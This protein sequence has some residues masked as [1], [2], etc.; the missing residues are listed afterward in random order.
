MKPSKLVVLIAV[1]IV[2]SI[3]LWGQVDPNVE[4][5][6]KPYGSFEGSDID[7]VSLTNG[8]LTIHQPLWSAPQRGN[9]GLTIDLIYNNKSFTAAR[10]PTPCGGTFGPCMTNVF[11]NGSGVTLLQSEG[12]SASCHMIPSSQVDQFGSPVN[13]NSCTALTADGSQ[14][15]LADTGNGYSQAIDGTGF[16]YYPATPMS[17]DAAGNANVSPALT[18]ANGNKISAAV[19]N[20]SSGGVDTLGRSNPQSITA[21]DI[22]LCPNLGYSFQSVNTAS[23]W[24]FAGPNGTTTLLMCFANVKV[25]SNF[26][27]IAGNHNFFDAVATTSMLQ[28][29]NLPD[30]TYYAFEYDAA[31]PNNSA[32]IAYGD[33]LKMTLPTGGSISYTWDTTIPCT[34]SPSFIPS[35]VVTSRKVDFND[36]NGAQ[37]WSYS[38]QGAGSVVVTDPLGK[39]TVHVITGLGGTCSLYE[40]ETDFYDGS[41]TGGTLLKTVKTDYSFTGNPYDMSAAPN[42]VAGVV[43]IHVTTI[44]PNGQQSRV[45][46]DYDS[47]FV[48]RDPLYGNPNVFPPQTHTYTVTYGRPVAKREYDWGQGAPGALLRQTL[49]TYQWQQGTN[50]YDTNNFR[51]LPYSVKILDGANHLCEETD[52]TY[53]EGTPATSNV[54]TGHGLAPGG[55]I[56]GNLTTVKRKLSTTPCAANATWSDVTSL[57]TWFDTGELKSSTDPGGHTTNHAYDPAYQGA[58]STQTCSPT[59][60]PGSIPHCVTGTYDFNTGLL[61]SFS[62]ENATQPATGNTQGDTNHT[63]TFA[64]DNMLRMTHAVSPVDPDPT[65]NNAKQDVAFGYQSAPVVFPETVTVQKL[66]TPALTDNSTAL[67][68]GLGRVFESD[69]SVQGG[70][71]TIVTKFDALSQVLS[72]TNPYFATA[73]PT[74]GITQWEYDA[75]GRVKTTIPQ[76]GTSASNNIRTDYSNFPTVTVTDQVGNPRSS[77]TDALGRLVE[78]DEPG[79]GANGPS[80]AGAGSIGISGTLHS[81]P[82]P[83]VKATGYVDISGTEVSGTFFVCFPDGSSVRQHVDDSGSVSIIVNGTTTSVG[84]GLGS[85]SST[86]ATALAGALNGGS[87]VQA[88]ASGSR[89]NFTAQTAGPNYSLSSTSASTAPT[90]SPLNSFS[91]APS[92]AAM[93]GGVAPSTTYDSGTLTVTVNGFQGSAAYN[94]N[95]NNTSTTLA[96]ALASALNVTGSPVNASAPGAS[97]TLT[98]KTTGLATN[99]SVTGSSTTSF[100]ASSTTLAGGSNAGGLFAPLVTYYSYDTLGNL[101]R[102]EQ[103]GG[104][105]DSTQWR[106]RTFTYD[107]LGRLLTAQNPESGTIRYSYDLDGNLLQKTSPLANQTG[108]ATQIVS[109]CY[110]ELHRVTDKSYT[111]QPPVIGQPCT[112]TGVVVHEAYDSGANAK[113]KL[114]SLADQAGTASYSYDVLGRLTGETRVI[115]G[116][117]K[118]LSYG[119]NVDGSIKTMTYP[120]G[121]TVTYTPDSASRSVSAIDSAHS[122]NYATGATYNAPGSMVYLINGSTGTFAGMTNTYSYNKRLQPINMSSVLPSQTVYSIGYDFHL[123]SGN[124][125]NVWGITNY[126][127]ANRN[128]T[129]TY[130]ALNRLAS[131]QNTGTDCLAKVLQNKNEYWGNSYS[132]DAWGN[133]TNKIVTKCGAEGLGVTADVH[134]WIHATSTPD[135]QYDA[136]GNMTFNATPPTQNYS[137]DPENRLTGAA[138]YAYIYDADGNRVEKVTP[139]PP[140]TPANGT[141]YWYMTPGIVGESDLAGTLKSEYVFFD[142]ER[143][144]RRDLSFAN[145]AYATVGVFYYFS[146]HL[147]TASVITD[148]AGVIKAESDYYPWGGELQFV[149]NDSNHYKFTGKE[150]DGGSGETG[151]D[152][153][154]AR[155]YSN[156]LGRFIT[157]DWSAV[158]VP[159]PY[160]DLID[161][162]SLNQYTYVR[163]IPTVNV[164]A[165]GHVGGVGVLE[166][167][168][169]EVIDVVAKPLIESAAPV[170]EGAAGFSSSPILIAAAIALVADHIFAPTVGQSDADERAQIKQASQERAQQNGGVDPQAAPAPKPPATASGGAR[171]GGGRNAQKSNQNRQ[172][173]AQDQLTTTKKELAAL[174]STPN[175]T[176]EEAAKVK[177]LE[178]KMKHLQKKA[179]QKSENHSQKQKGQQ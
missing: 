106:V 7:S 54:S 47:G 48:Y 91:T 36:H 148:S 111:P 150:R 110:D 154:G 4:Q 66:V 42:T 143:V 68:D 140:A 21:G 130:D 38:L 26:A 71:A 10:T 30:K 165:D 2:G 8:N 37:T 133:L 5:G 85:T 11:W 168:A 105:T 157:A 103:R 121:A 141:L 177:E 22:N 33:L 20:T 122:I 172:L 97:I 69:H 173:S 144:A 169:Q 41:H 29:V 123:G 114:T 100:T 108:S 90:C 77:R 95:L 27:S 145:G 151:L 18:D 63:K 62:N 31:D 35:R 84:Y 117:S 70:I 1:I 53:D 28:S 135:Y 102:V 78:V 81:T 125:G 113:G 16:R 104:T 89:V 67:F 14:H 155:Y 98:A 164:D 49:T 12:F 166:K 109:Y 19:S 50:S 124:N 112:L 51:D 126:K 147:K 163:N 60:S 65:N 86:I 64:Y 57:S 17:V 152:Y 6:M 45:E 129:F 59:T 76:D 156:G 158:P 136:A 146:D 137:Y 138:G 75:L 39:D 61:T 88:S 87:L 160:A 161:P 120:S 34:A 80:T 162:Q 118:S 73:D 153:F 115:S 101:L 127:D 178:K 15:I 175:K 44:L 139:P 99:Y 52:Y 3:S 46:T 82:N 170:A 13:F 128:Q 176:A 167:I 43:P 179:A 174:R 96:A 159:V 107:S 116:I 83:G 72:V 55:S 32:S 132:Y 93:T 149:N 25:H 131:A 94:Q 56:R 9:I 171:Q 58:Y 23:N 119:Y 74:Y 24:N 40:T 79:A 142:G 92:G 134:N